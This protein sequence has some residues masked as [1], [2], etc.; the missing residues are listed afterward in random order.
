MASIQATILLFP[1]LHIATVVNLDILYQDIFL[2]LSS[3][4][5]ATKYIPTDS[6]WSTDSNSF[7]CLD[8]RIYVLFT[9]NLYTCILQYNHN[10]ILDDHFSQ[11]KT[12]ELISYR[13]SW[14]SLYVDVQQFY[15]F[16]ATCIWSKPQCH[17]SYRSLKQLPIPKQLWNS[18]S[19]N[20]IKKLPSS[21]KFD[22]ILIIVDWLT[23]QVIFISA[24]NT[25]TSV[26]SLYILQT[27]CFFPCHLWQRFKVCVELLLF[28]RHCSKHTA[29]LHSRLLSWRQ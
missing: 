4:P 16:Y 11:N 18:I 2:A 29:S 12:L 17:K 14:P 10:Y 8:D 19:I 15:K 20:F 25:I 3:D 24:H 5:I 9:G 23:K 26:C 1:S 21:S 6:Q 13:Y 7:L 27:Q 28:F 22:T